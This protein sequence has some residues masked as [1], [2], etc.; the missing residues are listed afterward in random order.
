MVRPFARSEN[1]VIVASSACS[2]TGRPRP[3]AF[4]SGAETVYAAHAWPPRPRIS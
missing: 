3:Y 4:S 2:E 1:G